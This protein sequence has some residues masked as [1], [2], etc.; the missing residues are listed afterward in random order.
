MA[1][2]FM[3]EMVWQLVGARTWRARQVLC[4]TC[5]PD[6]SER[7]PHVAPLQKKALSSW[8]SAFFYDDYKLHE[9][10]MIEGIGV[11][12]KASRGDPWGARYGIKGESPDGAM[13]E[14]TRK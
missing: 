5:E 11:C 9:N 10:R 7:A 4:D 6:L 14:T 3:R 1:A 8:D 2:F 12:H 13:F